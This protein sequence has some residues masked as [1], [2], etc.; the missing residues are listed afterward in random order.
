MKQ[1]SILFLVALAAL[2]TG[3]SDF[4]IDPIG[5]GDDI[6]VTGKDSPFETIIRTEGHGS[7]INDPGQIIVANETEWKEL[8]TKLHNGMTSIPP[9]PAVDFS[10]STVIALFQGVQLSGGYDIGVTHITENEKGMNVS[11]QETVPGTD[12]PTTATITSPCHIVKIAKKTGAVE[13]QGITV[14]R[15]CN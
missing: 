10:T 3:C 13:F 4:P 11:F 7:A 1:L 14:T 8:W 15:H 2:F 5:G 12:C 9:V 6:E